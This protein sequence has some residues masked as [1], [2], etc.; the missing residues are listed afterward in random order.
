MACG[1][2]LEAGRLFR[3]GTTL[4]R[5]P[6]T[7]SVKIEASRV[8]W[9]DIAKGLCILLVVMM[10]ATLGVEK[11]TGQ[12]TVLNGFIEWA[13]PFRMPDFFLISGLFL[14]ARINRPWRPYLDS[15]V[16]YFAYFYVLWLTIQ[17]VVKAPGMV[18]EDGAGTTLAAYLTGLVQ[19]WGTL[20]FIYMLAVFFVAAKLLAGAPKALVWAAAT[21]IYFAAPHTGWLIIDEFAARFVFFF[22]GYW[23]APYIFRF[24][25]EVAS[26]PAA[27]VA[28][29]LAAWAALNWLAVENGLAFAT[30]LDLWVSFA[31]VVAVVGF[32]VL[33]VPT[34]LG[35]TLAMLG[36]NSIKIYL[37]F[38]LFM[39]PA[40]IVA[41]K[42]GSV[43][44]DW[45]AALVSTS[46]GVAGALALA[47][48]VK[49]T[50]FAFLFS[51]PDTL[52]LAA[53]AGAHA[54]PAR[55]VAA[56]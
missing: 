8:A 25:D 1:K 13:K 43:I 30:G 54:A 4:F 46:A 9:V 16:L 2:T 37:A 31:G 34:W 48:I 26:Q 33:L 51:R 18:A 20:W 24:A 27:I 14:A 50:R 22:T 11:A 53:T 12:D 47:H 55:P 17:F 41:L 52:S 5:K 56:T 7:M 23:A 28:G 35:R 45:A 19:P 15:K 3:T 40:R 10:H 42:F 38:P 36:R 49:G 6:T 44:P 32:A 39:G 21:M 29:C